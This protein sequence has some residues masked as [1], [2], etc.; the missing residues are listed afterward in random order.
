MRILFSAC[1]VKEKE[2]LQFRKCGNGVSCLTVGSLEISVALYHH[3]MQQFFLEQTSV[4]GHP[5]ADEL[6]TRT[7]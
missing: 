7:E 4:D 1:I 6:H 5:L 2:L 3:G